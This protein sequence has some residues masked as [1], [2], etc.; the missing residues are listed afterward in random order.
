MASQ[1]QKN[2]EVASNEPRKQ[3]LDQFVASAPTEKR[4]KL[5]VPAAPAFA[6]LTSKTNMTDAGKKSMARSEATSPA[7]SSPLAGARTSRGVAGGFGHGAASFG[8][9]VANNQWQ[10]NVAQNQA[11][12]PPP[13][14]SFAKQQSNQP[15][16]TQ[17]PASTETVEVS[18]AAP[19]ISTEAQN[20]NAPLLPSADQAMVARA[21]SPVAAGAANGASVSGTVGVPV[22][23]P[24]AAPN[25]PSEVRNVAAIGVHSPPLL[26]LWTITSAGALQRSFDQGKTWQSVDVSASLI[27]SNFASNDATSLNISA[28]TSSTKEEKKKAKDA[29]KSLKRPVATPAFRAVAASGSEV[30]AG[31]SWGLLYHSLDS[32]NHWTRIVPAA[33]G[34]SLTGDILSIEFPDPQH[35][36]LSTSTSETW[37]TTDDGGTWQKQ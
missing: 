17:V 7:I 1:N 4:E 9:R 22:P 6:D 29:D 2:L 20:V 25:L 31:G 35:G 24:A 34:T 14:M 21:K 8:P 36:R 37:I 10:Q 23:S 33:A 18:G 13:P 30:W 5:Q 32:G 11:S 16:N 27:A 15:A 12:A 26:P 28:S 3:A 19:M